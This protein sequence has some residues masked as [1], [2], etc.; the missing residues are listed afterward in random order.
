MNLDLYEVL[1]EEISDETAAHLADIFMGL[2]LAIE[3]HY[4]PQIIRHLKAT[5]PASE[6]PSHS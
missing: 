5:S 6:N 4:Y 2:A 1:P 3:N